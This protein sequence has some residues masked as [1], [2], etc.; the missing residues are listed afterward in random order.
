MRPVHK[1]SIFLQV[2]ETTPNNPT[3]R[4]FPKR[5]ESDEIVIAT[6]VRDYPSSAKSCFIHAG[7]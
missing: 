3:S 1:H 5:R 2:G 7:E 6:V 4:S